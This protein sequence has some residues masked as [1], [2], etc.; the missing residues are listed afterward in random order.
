MTENAEHCC[1]ICKRRLGTSDPLTSSCG[2]DCMR[3]MAYAGDPDCTPEVMF[4]MGFRAG[5][6]AEGGGGYA[7]Q[8]DD[9]HAVED[10]AWAAVSEGGLPDG[11]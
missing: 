1:G 4:R 10:A 5:V 9:M 7:C 3:C 2:G 6:Y 11:A 8:S